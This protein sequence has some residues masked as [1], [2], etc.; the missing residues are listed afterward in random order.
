MERPSSDQ[1]SML[2]NFLVQSHGPSQLSINRCNVVYMIYIISY[3]SNININQK[4][5]SVLFSLLSS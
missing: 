3:N 4:S 1:W 2:R 5:Y